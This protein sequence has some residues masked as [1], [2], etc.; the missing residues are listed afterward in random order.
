M[1][2]PDELPTPAINT[3][4]LVAIED[5]AASLLPTKKPDPIWSYPPSPDANPMVAWRWPNLTIAITGPGGPNHV[6]VC[7]AL[8]AKAEREGEPY[9]R[10]MNFGGVG[11]YEWSGLTLGDAVF[12]RESIQWNFFY[13]SRD[14]AWYTE[15]ISDLEV[16]DSWTGRTCLS[17]SLFSTD[18]DRQYPVFL[19]GDVEEYELYALSRVGQCLGIPVTSLKF[20]TNPVGPDG[21]SVYLKELEETRE[22]AT[23]ILRDFLAGTL[24]AP[25]TY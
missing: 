4:L 20:V 25:W 17:G 8:T 21:A 5:E 19:T 3:L 14:W 9:A 2:I 12:I 16:P 24:H 11:A 7:T 6:A 13:P 10:L 1:T 23:Q 22:K 18:R 15:P